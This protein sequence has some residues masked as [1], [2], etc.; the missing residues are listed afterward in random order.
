MYN[1]YSLET[2]K[3]KLRQARRRL[4]IIK[5]VAISVALTHQTKPE[6]I[7]DKSHHSLKEW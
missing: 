6:M 1:F 4:A 7:R 3:F 5:D 2:M